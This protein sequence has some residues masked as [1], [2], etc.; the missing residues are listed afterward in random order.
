MTAVFFK[1]IWLFSGHWD[2]RKRVFLKKFQ[3][4]DLIIIPSCSR[5]TCNLC[6]TFYL[7]LR[8][9]ILYFDLSSWFDSFTFKRWFVDLFLSSIVNDDWFI[10]LLGNNLGHTWVLIWSNWL[11]IFAM[12]CS[13]QTQLIGSKYFMCRDLIQW[14]VHGEKYWR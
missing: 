11:T 13:Y 8:K 4:N 3:L 5:C 9:I 14:N 10:F 1:Y 7:F 12:P 2:K 6:I